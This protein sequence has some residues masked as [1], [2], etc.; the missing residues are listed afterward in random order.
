MTDKRVLMITKVDA[1]WNKL[2]EFHKYWGEKS[3]P[4]WEEN[5]AKHIGSFVNH[6]G[7]P[8]NQ[9]VRL[10][11]GLKIFRRGKSLCKPVRRGG[12]LNKDK[13]L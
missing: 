11:F 9:I 10:F 1:V 5:G 4:V 12:K 7:G 2:E 6:L 13:S 8:K 3:L